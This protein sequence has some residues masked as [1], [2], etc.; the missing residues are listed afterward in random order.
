MRGLDAERD[1]RDAFKVK[2]MVDTPGWAVMERFMLARLDEVERR[3][4]KGELTLE[5]YR[6][7]TGE[8]KGLLAIRDEVANHLK[9]A[10]NVNT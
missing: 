5:E 4:F 6:S 9:R 8:R 3:I 7:Y 10:Q 1:R 2:A